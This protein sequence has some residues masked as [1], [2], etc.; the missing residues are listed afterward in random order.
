[1]RLTLDIDHLED[2]TGESKRV[3]IATLRTEIPGLE[4]FNVV[5]EVPKD[6]TLG[7]EVDWIMTDMLKQKQADMKEK[8]KGKVKKLKAKV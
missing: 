6:S 5:A 8:T 4:K 1:M 2:A 3:M 7:K